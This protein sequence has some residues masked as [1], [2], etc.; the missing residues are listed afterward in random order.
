M[1]RRLTAPW[2]TATWL[3]LST[4]GGAA[5]VAGVVLTLTISPWLGVPSTA[6]GTAVTWLAYRTLRRRAN[7]ARQAALDI[8]RRILHADLRDQVRTELLGMGGL[9]RFLQRHRVRIA[10]LCDLVGLQVDRADDRFWRI[11]DPEEPA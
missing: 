3:Q 7:H 1:S 5:A 11:R 2:S 4:L 6:A 9:P 10:A 8:E